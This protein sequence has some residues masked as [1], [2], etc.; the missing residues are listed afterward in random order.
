MSSFGSGSFGTATFGG[1]PSPLLLFSVDAEMT[2]RARY[3]LA[4]GSVDGTSLWPKEFSVGTGG[5]DAYDY[6]VALPVNP[7]SVTL[8]ADLFRDTI[9]NYEEPNDQC[10][11][12]HCI[13]ENGEANQTLGEIGIWA[14]IQNSPVAGENGTQILFA[15]GHFPLQAKNSSMRYGLRVIV[16]A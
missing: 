5:F 14:E 9:D 8:D 11:S 13:L 12:F 1:D 4:R 15:I 2:T 3:I 6:A 10:A 7:D 16:Q